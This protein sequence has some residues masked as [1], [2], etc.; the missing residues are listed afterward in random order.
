[1]SQAAETW[2]TTRLA[3]PE[4]VNRWTHG[5]GFAASLP[6]AAV[7]LWAASG[8]SDGWIAVACAVYAGSLVALYAAS[9]LSH[10][11]EDRPQLRSGFRVADQVCIYL[12]IAGTFTPFAAAHLRTP[13]G[14]G[15]LAAV[16][17]LAA[18]G[19]ALR[20]RRKGAQIGPSDVALCL[21]TGWIPILSLGRF[22]SIGGPDGF[23]L[24]LAGGLFYSGGTVFLLNDHRNPYLHG[25][26][27]VST[28]A[29]SGCHYLFLLNYVATA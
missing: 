23:A 21:L 27:H 22:V 8:R 20:V 26:W 29:G 7:L 12:L 13:F 9:A 19:I 10:G 18:V 28:L 24:V 6:A 16:W 2:T 4:A 25:V 3:P 15:Q 14:L 17:L 1:M 5:L 11:F